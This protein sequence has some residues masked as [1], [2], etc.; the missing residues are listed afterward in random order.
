VWS[1]RQTELSRELLNFDGVSVKSLN[2]EFGVLRV[3][4]NPPAYTVFF[5]DEAKTA[6]FSSVEDLIKA[7]WAVD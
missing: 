4:G 2:G 7:G 6:A 5:Y 1:D 3:T